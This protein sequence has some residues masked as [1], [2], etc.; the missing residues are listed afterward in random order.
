MTDLIKDY[1]NIFEYNDGLLG[2]KAEGDLDTTWVGQNFVVDDVE[3]ISN[4]VIADM[5]NAHLEMQDIVFSPASLIPDAASY[6]G[7][8]KVVAPFTFKNAIGKVL[9][10]QNVLSIDIA[11][12][13]VRLTFTNKL[14]I[15]FLLTEIKLVNLL[16]NQLVLSHSAPL[17]IKS[18]A[19]E[20]IDLDV[21][22]KQLTTF[23]HWQI[24]G[25]SPG[26]NGAVTVKSDDS[27]ELSV[28]LVNFRLTSI[29]TKSDGFEVEQGDSV[30]IGEAVCIREA[31]FKSGKITFDIENHL[32]M[33]LQ[34][35]IQS[36]QFIDR[37]SK[38]PLRCQTVVKK[39][40][41]IHK[42]LP[43]VSYKIAY[44]GQLVTPQC[45]HL[46]IQAKGVKE[47]EQIV[48]LAGN[49]TI[50]FAFGMRGAVIDEFT[51]RLKDYCV[52]INPITQ[53]VVLP[54]N[55]EPFRGLNMN[56][57]LLS[58]DFYSTIEMPIHFE[59]TLA[60]FAADNGTASLPIIGDLA[61][62]ELGHEEATRL[63]FD[64]AKN[65]DVLALVNLPPQRVQF[66]GTTFVGRGLE[67]GSITPNN[68]LR[69]HYILETPA[70]LAWK[71]TE[72]KPDTTYFQINPAIY[73][74]PP[75]R[76]NVIQLAAKDVNQLQSFQLMTDIE[77]HLPVSGAIEFQLQQDVSQSTESII[78]LSPVDVESARIN[79]QGRIE[80][81]WK[82][83]YEIEL[84]NED[85]SIFRNYS[86]DPKL[87]T[88]VRKIKM[89]G[90]NGQKVKLYD[91]DYLIVGSAVQFVINM[92]Q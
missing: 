38:E 76:Q 63:T 22:G 36:S 81:S 17:T 70:Y 88:L 66:S 61:P 84:N 60:G 72:F 43:L 28:D 2:L 49:E 58:F 7:Q 79:V 15:D 91:S 10:E 75:L 64:S 87:L 48:T 30:A 45:I 24:A 80:K 27:L 85:L 39:H 42:E 50:G 19:T 6:S 1:E 52:G 78:L 89:N 69:A 35:D 44:Q 20:I 47:N 59:G 14:P 57:A 3:E 32:S 55:L 33:D 73:D 26:S 23:C 62:G 90:T 9:S 8:P 53:P 71:D 21:S 31:T 11:T 29:T 54:K 51:G 25:S 4:I 18:G 82:Q 16:S 40:D 37:M 86:D 13:L 83:K 68:Y 77:N 12:G 5:V 92:P 67:E 65:P 74:G 56:D 34:V 46:V 41:T